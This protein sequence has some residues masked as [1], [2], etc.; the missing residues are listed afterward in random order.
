MSDL[1]LYPHQVTGVEFLK[2]RPG[3]ALLWDEQRVGKTPQAIVASGELGFKRIVIIT[4]VSGVAVWRHQWRQWDRWN[5]IPLI[6]PW[7]QMSRGGFAIPGTGKAQLL[8]LDEGHYAKSF[9]AERTRSVYGQLHGARLIQDRALVPRCERVWHLTGTPMP[10]DPGDLF[11]VLRSLFPEALVSDFRGLPDVTTFEKFRSRYCVMVNKRIGQR[12]IKVVIRGQNTDELARR[13][14]GMFLRRRQADVGIRPAFWDMLPVVL[15]AGERQRLFQAID[16][17]NLQRIV[18][19]GRFGDL[20]PLLAPVRRIT[21]VVKAKAMVPYVADFLDNCDDKLVLMY[22]HREVGDMLETSLG[23]YFP[24]R[25][26]GATSA[27]QR[28]VNLATFMTKPHCRLFLGQ[29]AACGEAIDLSVASETW[30]VESTFTPAQMAQAGARITN[31]RQPRQCLVRVAAI[32]ET[33]DEMIQDR[34]IDL[35]R[36][37][38]HTLGETY[39]EDF[40]AHR[41]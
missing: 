9:G 3:H 23:K 21:G 37:I 30:F 15:N 14:K 27:D 25:V 33:I 13:M 28:A 17:D 4:T 1:S 36:S 11:P 22:W 24:V 16:H 26:D 6:V 20:E 38:A 8:I 34:L 18:K 29:I 7:S 31:L 39:R 41:S 5:R 12:V 32:E 10:H 35:S 19:G 2:S 40:S